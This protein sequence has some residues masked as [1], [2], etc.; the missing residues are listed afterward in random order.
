MFLVFCRKG[1][2]SAIGYYEKA[3]A[4]ARKAR[5]A[6]RE[7]LGH[8][9]LGQAKLA[10]GEAEAAITELELAC[11]LAE[12]GGYLDTL[13]DSVRALSEARLAS[14]AIDSA[15]ETALLAVRHGEQSGNPYF[16]A[17]AH[18]AAMDAYLAKAEASRDR[19]VF[20]DAV[21]HREAAVSLFR[22]NKQ[23]HLA[24]IVENRFGRG[25]N[26]TVNT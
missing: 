19:A 25:S 26:L 22:E 5:W 10:A 6:S 2:T 17:M 24:E 18:G 14:G 1:F 7:A 16:E 3:L 20:E 4:S 11:G 21:L 23:P 15:I 12:E 9:N 13:A 8:S